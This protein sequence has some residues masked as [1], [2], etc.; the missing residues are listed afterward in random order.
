MSGCTRD[1]SV[2]NPGN[3]DKVDTLP[4]LMVRSLAANL[5]PY[6]HSRLTPFLR[7]VMTPVS[8]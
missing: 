5:G 8:V 2:S 3:V 4:R 6:L 1:R 7:N